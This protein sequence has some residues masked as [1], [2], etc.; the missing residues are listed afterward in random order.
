MSKFAVI[1]TQ[2]HQYLVEEGQELLVDRLKNKEPE[3]SVLMVSD[4]D[5]AEIGKP[6]LPNKIKIK[7][8]EAEVK[9][10]KIEVIKYKSKSR[11]RRHTGFR[12]KYTKL[13]I[14]KIS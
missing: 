6:T 5:K 2:G 7:V 3:I 11:Y 8:V 13:L 14:E 4:G 9:G 1:K 12:P 10:T